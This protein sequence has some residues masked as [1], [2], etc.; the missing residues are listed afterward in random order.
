M[1]TGGT[2][3]SRGHNPTPC[4]ILNTSGFPDQAAFLLSQ[5]QAIALSTRD[6]NVIPS[7]LYL[8]VLSLFWPKCQAFW[9]SSVAT[10]S[11]SLV[12]CI[13]FPSGPAPSLLVDMLSAATVCSPPPPPSDCALG[14]ELLRVKPAPRLLQSEAWIPTWLPGTLV[15]P[16]LRAS[17]PSACPENRL[18]TA[19]SFRSTTVHFCLR[20]ER[21]RD[22][23]HRL[24]QVSR[25]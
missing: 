17:E 25:K 9:E 4:A 16:F 24:A 6:P 2:S 21:V 3:E 13:P 12:I 1:Y 10:P 19:G 15:P 18:S 7:L 20:S 5:H 11:W 23:L 8:A 14:E 22:T